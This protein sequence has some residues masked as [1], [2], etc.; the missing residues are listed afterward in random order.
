MEEDVYLGAS[1]Q[2]FQQIY[3]WSDGDLV[4]DWSMFHTGNAPTTNRYPNCLHM[5][6]VNSWTWF[7]NSC[8]E[9]YTFICEKQIVPYDVGR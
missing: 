3:Q 7:D 9:Q 2:V 1:D 5:S 8:S 6:Y 4:A